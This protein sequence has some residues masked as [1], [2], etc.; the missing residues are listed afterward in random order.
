[1]SA[2]PPRAP[3]LAA[4]FVSFVAALLP[5]TAAAQTPAALANFGTYLGGS[6]IDRIV[7]VAQYQSDII[8]VG[9][10]R[11]ASIEAGG[12]T[13]MRTTGADIFVA[14]FQESGVLNT[15]D[16]TPAILVF[17]GDGDDEPI[18]MLL[19]PDPARDIY[20]VGK[21]TSVGGFAAGKAHGSA[22]A[23]TNAFVA[24]VT[25]TNT[26]YEWFMFLSGNG[27]DVATD[28]ALVNSRLY[29]S[30]W[31]RST[32]F[33]GVTGLPAG[34]NGFVTEIIPP[35]A[36]STAPTVGWNFKPVVFGGALD[37][38][39]LGITASTGGALHVTGTTSSTSFSYGNKVTNTFKGGISDAWIAQ[40]AAGTG[41]LDWMA[42][43]GGGGDDQGNAIAS[44][45]GGFAVAGTT[46][47]PGNL[48]SGAGLADTNAFI[49]WMLPTGQ[50]KF[51]EVRQGSQNDVVQALTL[52]GS[53]NAYVGGKTG[54]ATFA[55]VGQ[56]GF[57]RVI[58]A[59]T[60]TELRE[61]F[62]W[63]AP[64]E[65]G[66]GWSSYVG[67]DGVDEVTSL[68]LA[69][70]DK[71]IIGMQTHST[72]G[73]PGLGTPPNTYDATW[74]GKG[75]GYL[76]SV[77]VVD[78]SPPGPGTIIDRPQ[79]DLSQVDIDTTSTNAIYANWTGFADST[80]I[81]KFEWAIGTQAN[82]IS[83]QGLTAVGGQTSV[84]APS[85]PLVAGQKYVVTV[86]ATNTYGLTRTD[87]SDGVLVTYPDGG[88]PP[89]SDAGTPDSGTPE[90][91]A[92][93][94]DPDAGTPEPDAGTPDSGTP[95][96]GT[97]GGTQGPDGGG[98]GG[99][100]DPD[101][102]PDSPVG[103][104]CASGGGAVPLLVVLGLF[105]LALLSRRL[106]DR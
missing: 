86:R 80:G 74:G 61:G 101:E 34:M 79:Q 77:A 46:S 78:T 28:V 97:D 38:S 26:T 87:M 53:G 40:L 94:P 62:V 69:S 29:V 24:K 102:D 9:T 81:V 104:G 71:L 45:A 96:P 12:A 64:P 2:L 31:T 15:D 5:L 93:T 73:M 63:M 54:S 6:E 57:D 22:P 23:G 75:D 84:A 52:D 91:D 10:T 88:V 83:I 103:F 72:T 36:P 67:S 44:T 11:S 32:T 89:P 95:N 1:M 16:F 43:L 21:T 39:F 68:S 99:G 33:M 65:G 17:G 20:I 42:F 105:A 35:S 58:E 51:S 49:A 92:G 48:G 90:P 56:T 66:D 47:S 59:N 70:S 7:G 8:V 19:G 4:A 85:L 55:R 27:E 30:G 18:G 37:D 82:P 3:G 76:L 100:G 60:G 25:G 13:G 41:A 50:L 14:H 98:G 106:G